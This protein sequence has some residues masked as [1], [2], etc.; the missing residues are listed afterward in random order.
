MAN[1]YG[2]FESNWQHEVS[3]RGVKMLDIGY[4][5][6]TSSIIGYVFARI[7][8]H[9]FKFDKKYYEEKLKN[10]Y[11]K[12]KVNLQLIFEI[13]IEMAIIGI[14]VYSGRQINQ[15]LPFPLDGYKGLNPPQGF[16]GFRHKKLREWENPYPIA[17][18]I[19][20]FQDALKAKI[21]YFTE[22]NKL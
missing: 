14:V 21:N 8:A 10:N 20:L 9:I 19:I 5:F 4:L 15:L 16:V 6:A 13:I 22:I 2:T 18:F 3:I 1:P 12:W 11:P 17:F 7:L